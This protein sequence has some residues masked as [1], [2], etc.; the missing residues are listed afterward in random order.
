MEASRINSDPRWSWSR[1]KCKTCCHTAL[2][3]LTKNLTLKTTQVHRPACIAQLAPTS[4]DKTLELTGEVQMGGSKVLASVNTSA[5]FNEIPT[6]SQLHVGSKQFSG[7]FQWAVKGQSKWSQ[8]S[9]WCSTV[10]ITVLSAVLKWALQ[11]TGTQWVQSCWI[12]GP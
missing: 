2:T 12:L 5:T 9:S 4:A 3:R 10:C 8:P 6:P 7:C 11:C 1:H